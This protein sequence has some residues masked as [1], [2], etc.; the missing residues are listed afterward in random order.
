MHYYHVSSHAKE[1]Q[2]FTKET[3]NNFNYCEFMCVNDFST[4]EKSF[5]LYKEML[6]MDLYSKTGRNASKWL[7][8][9]IFEYVRKHN[10]HT[11]LPSRVWGVYLCDTKEHAKEFKNNERGKESKIFEVNV[12]SAITLNMN[13]FTQ[14]HKEIVETDFS[15]QSYEN[16]VNYA[17]A[18]WTGKNIPGCEYIPEYIALDKEVRIGSVVE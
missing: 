7:C 16:V 17:N 14:A 12:C 18:Y 8:E 13:L 9:A 4:Y 11:D 1:G 5:N 3:K 2:I 15:A 6:K 10:N